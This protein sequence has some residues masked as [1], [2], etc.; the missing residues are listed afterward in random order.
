[1]E[2]S[3][4]I[5]LGLGD[6]I[7][8]GFS[9]ISKLLIETLGL[10]VAIV[11]QACGIIVALLGAARY[12]W[13]ALSS[14]WSQWFMSYIT[15]SSNDRLHEQVMNYMSA[16]VVQESTRSL[17]AKASEQGGGTSMDRFSGSENQNDVDADIRKLELAVKNGAHALADLYQ[18]RSTLQRKA[19][20]IS[21]TK[22]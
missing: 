1:M 8:P 3:Q 22:V 18:H 10:D 5:P 7:F 12:L 9:I 2:A 21:G 14:L 6:A 13:R 16:K 11:I 17:N 20:I 15:I 19:S 4:G